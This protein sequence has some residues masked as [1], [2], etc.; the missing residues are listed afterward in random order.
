[1]A[2]SRE[3]VNVVNISKQKNFQ[4]LLEDPVST[5]SD[6]SSEAMEAYLKTVSTIGNK[7]YAVLSSENS[8]DEKL[9]IDFLSTF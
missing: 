3:V 5:S 6:P 4:N 2:C 8:A 7:M 1:M 9:W